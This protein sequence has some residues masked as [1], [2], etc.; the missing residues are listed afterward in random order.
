M[1]VFFQ[2]PDISKN[3][4]RFPASPAINDTLSAYHPTSGTGSLNSVEIR[5]GLP[6]IF[7]RERKRV[8]S[9]GNLVVVGEVRKTT[10]VSLS[11]EMN[12]AC[13]SQTRPRS[14]LPFLRNA[15]TDG[16][17]VCLSVFLSVCPSVGAFLKNGES[18]LSRIWLARA[19]FISVE[20][21][22]VVVF[23]TSLTTHRISTEFR[24]PVPNVGRYALSVSFIACGDGKRKIFLLISGS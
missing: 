5:C 7:A 13:A 1:G 14:D 8:Q 11:T 20:R 10:T 4:F 17:S 23:L 22:T 6:E 21:E 16:Q 15:P 2:N 12:S 18:D 24:L 19:E 3:I 9:A